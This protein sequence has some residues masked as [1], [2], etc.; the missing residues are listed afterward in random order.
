MHIIKKYETSVTL[1]SVNG[2]V[3]VYKSKRAAI[4]ELGYYWIQNNV[5][6]DFVTFSH[7]ERLWSADG[8]GWTERPVYRGANYVM[9]DDL[10]EA[11]TVG[12]FA[13]FKPVYRP[14]WYRKLE[15]WNG[16]GPVPGISRPRGY[17]WTRRVGTTNERRQAQVLDEFDVPPRARRNARNLPTVWDDIPIAAREDRN[18]KRFRKTQWKSKD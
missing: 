18:W 9:R 7:R 2:G 17:R 13:E 8:E 15:N 14:R 4:K 12:D 1:F 11:L 3:W 16:V 10:G 5:A 6:K